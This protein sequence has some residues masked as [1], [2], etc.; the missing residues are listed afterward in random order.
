M[1]ADIVGVRHDGLYVVGKDAFACSFTQLFAEHH[2][3]IRY[4]VRCWKYKDTGT[5]CHLGVQI[6][7][8]GSVS[9]FCC[10]FV[11]FCFVCFFFAF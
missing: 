2:L 1:G 7:Y 4:C 6:S 9:L 10:L 8:H 5:V 11:L 3:C